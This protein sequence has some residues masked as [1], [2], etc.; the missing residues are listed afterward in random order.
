MPEGSVH[1]LL[2]VLLWN[3]AASRAPHVPCTFCDELDGTGPDGIMNLTA[4]AGDRVK[5]PCSFSTWKSDYQVVW[6]DPFETTLFFNN[7]RLVEEGRFELERHGNEWNLLISHVAYTDKGKYRCVANTQPTQK[8]VIDLQVQVPPK[9][10]KGLS[11]SRDVEV[12]EGASVFLM[13]NASGVPP[14]IIRWTRRPADNPTQPPQ[15]LPHTG[16]E[17]TI[18]NASRYCDDIYQCIASN[19]VEP[20]DKHS[21]SVKVRFSPEVTVRTSRIMQ[22]LGMKTTLACHAR[23]Y[24]IIK[25]YWTKDDMEIMRDHS[26]RHKYSYVKMGTFILQASLDIDDIQ[27]ED[28]GVYK[29]VAINNV[30][31]AEVRAE[32]VE[33]IP[34]LPVQES[35]R[36]RM[37]T[38][39]GDTRRVP[40]TLGVSKPRPSDE[41]GDVEYAELQ[42]TPRDKQTEGPFGDEMRPSNGQPR[43]LPPRTNGKDEVRS[44][45]GSSNGGIS[46]A[47]RAQA[48]SGGPK[49]P[50]NG[51]NAAAAAGAKHTPA[52][53]V[54]ALLASAALSVLSRV[55]TFGIVR[56]T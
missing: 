41:E 7:E 6:Q 15:Y 14:P 1:V 26:P 28:Y 33:N 27:K 24:P 12:T 13:C 5:L 9:I 32:L 19:G 45:H 43:K 40:P 34:E 53:L 52:C 2:L 42:L 54:A 44:G 17:L 29:C 11:S 23:M 31:R 51:K 4:R 3:R 35:L 48:V 37:E 38:S 22:F 56:T 25:V 55:P 36:P 16:S 21:V 39:E 20:S 46:E 10:Y 47:K 8:K 50:A 30:G 49:P 18:V